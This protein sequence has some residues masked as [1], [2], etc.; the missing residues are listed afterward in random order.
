MK[1]VLALVL[2]MM[3]GVVFAD[4]RQPVGF[5]ASLNLNP[6]MYSVGSYGFAMLGEVGNTAVSLQMMTPV[7]NEERMSGLNLDV[8]YFPE[9][10]S[11]F[12]GFFKLGVGIRGT[13]LKLVDGVR[14]N[15][16]IVYDKNH[17]YVLTQSLQM[18][19]PTVTLQMVNHKKEPFVYRFKLGVPFVLGEKLK[20]AEGMSRKVWPKNIMFSGALV[21]H[22]PQ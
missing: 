4:G 16:K 9:K 12:E 11:A 20:L 18:I 3:C 1:K 17:P 21:Y 2:V 14:V 8:D 19:T 15:N 6:K 13:T 22:L 7:F 10:W 5:S